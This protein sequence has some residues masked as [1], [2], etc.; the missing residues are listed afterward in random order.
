MLDHKV[1]NRTQQRITIAPTCPSSTWLL[2][3]MN[4]W[5]CLNDNNERGR[6]EYRDL[7][8]KVLVSWIISTQGLL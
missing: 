1:C 7:Y 8:S 4:R 3:H 5:S 6:R 2:P